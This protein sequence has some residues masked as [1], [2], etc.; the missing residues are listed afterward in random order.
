MSVMSQLNLEIS[1]PGEIGITKRCA[2]CGTA[3]NPDR[4]P[5]TTIV[6]D[7]RTDLMCDPCVTS[8]DWSQWEFDPIL[9][10]YRRR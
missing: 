5:I 7:W 1:R 10:V 8:F 9:N 3:E 2:N 4:A 6:I